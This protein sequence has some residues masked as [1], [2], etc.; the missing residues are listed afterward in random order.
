M[1][2]PV[3]IKMSESSFMVNRERAI[4][5]L[6]TRDRLFVVD[7]CA[8]P[9]KFVRS[10]ARAALTDPPARR[11]GTLVGRRAPDRDPC[12]D[13]ARTTRSSSPQQGEPTAEEAANFVP[14]YRSS[15]PAASPPTG[16][17]RR[18]IRRAMLYNF[19]QR[20]QMDG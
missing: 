12:G 18:A 2:G 19:G 7:A 15:T 16:D 6:N 4:D 3:N 11:A 9:R 17:R 1:V 5:Y 13:V 20:A 10:R 8:A 14:D